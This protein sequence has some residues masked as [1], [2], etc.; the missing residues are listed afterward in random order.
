MGDG[1]ISC[2]ADENILKLIVV[3]VVQ[4]CECTTAIELSTL[5]W[6]NCVL[7]ELYL[8]KAITNKQKKL[9]RL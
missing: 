6:V 2:W 7:C 9:P 3:T 5:K 4:L 1:G 8:K